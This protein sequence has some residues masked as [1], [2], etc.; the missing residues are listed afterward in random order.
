MEYTYYYDS[1]LGGITLAS[2]GKVL[3]G[4]WFNGQ[5]YFA[6][7][8]SK[9]YIK[10]NLPIFKQTHQWLNI[11]FSGKQP[12]F[13]PLL[14]IETTPF[15]KTVWKILLTIPFGQTITYGEIANMIT[16]SE[17]LS[18]MSARAIGNAVSHNP[19]LLIIP[20]H[21]VIGKNKNL[22]GYAAGIDKKRYL[23][24]MECI[25][26]FSINSKYN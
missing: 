26:T 20:C 7:T 5:K 21:R 11:Y 16:N 3:T 18:V 2:D 23:L 14:K 4:L 6:N 17:N 24:E 22:I 9:D 1:P 19:I 8:L 15:R 13:I 10:K 12:N 25:N